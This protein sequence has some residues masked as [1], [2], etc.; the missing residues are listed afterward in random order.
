[1]FKYSFIYSK[2]LCSICLDGLQHMMVTNSIDFP[3]KTRRLGTQKFGESESLNGH[4]ITEINKVCC[5]SSNLFWDENMMNLTIAQ[6][7]YHPLPIFH[8]FL[9]TYLRNYLSCSSFKVQ[10]SATKSLETKACCPH[11]GHGQVIFSRGQE[12]SGGE[13]IIINKYV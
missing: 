10:L 9:E 3:N 7:W 11:V 8:K 4:W 13:T 1:M 12:D 5:C 6:S 2:F